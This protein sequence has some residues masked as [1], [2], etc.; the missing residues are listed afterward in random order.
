MWQNISKCLPAQDGRVLVCCQ[1]M[2]DKK[3]FIMIAWYN[4]GTEQP[5]SLL[6]E[7]WIDSISH[8]SEL[9]APPNSQEQEEAQKQYAAPPNTDCKK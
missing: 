8:W 2:D 5:W 3:P 6:P 1:S 7:V 4:P 9:T